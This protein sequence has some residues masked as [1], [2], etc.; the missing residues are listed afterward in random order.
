MWI[1][2]FC[3][4]RVRLLHRVDIVWDPRACGDSVIHYGGRSSFSRV[5]YCYVPTG[6]IV[7]VGHYVLPTNFAKINNRRDE[8]FR[9]VQL[10]YVVSSL[11][12][13]QSVIK[14]SNAFFRTR[15]VFEIVISSFSVWSQNIVD[16]L[17]EIHVN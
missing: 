13:R 7:I 1:F 10:S 15:I 11:R 8:T 16:K 9:R 3:E 14:Y 2:R 12:T 4:R 6:L 17:Q 5:V